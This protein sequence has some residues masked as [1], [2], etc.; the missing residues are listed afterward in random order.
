M[1]PRSSPIMRVSFSLLTLTC[2]MSV[3]LAC[4]EKGDKGDK[5]GKGEKKEKKVSVS[6]V[7]ILASET[8]DKIDKKL[9]S[10]AKEVQKMHP[11][12]TNFEMAKLSCKSVAVGKEDKFDLVEDQT[13][14][15]TVQ[16][17]ADKMDRICLK[18]SPPMMG[19]ITYST[20]CGKF[21]PILTPYRTKKDQVV[22][23]AIR[24]QPCNGGGK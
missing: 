23:I 11:K 4:G 2:A 21:L 16:K 19:E 7:V 10:I 5:D 18:V 9:T 24:V 20:P 6:V 13:T 14:N 8:G 3:V 12:L 1:T 22:I 15:I 17:A